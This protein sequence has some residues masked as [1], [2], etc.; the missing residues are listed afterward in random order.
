LTNRYYDLRPVV[1][2]T[3]TGLD[4][5][6]AMKRSA[7]R[8]SDTYM[9]I[10][11][12]YLVVAPDAGDLKPLLERGWTLLGEK[13]GLPP[14]VAWTDDYINILASAAAKFGAK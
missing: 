13:D 7:L 5:T 2:A 6:G 10:A 1:K 14:G 9:P 8:S 3:L 4:L 12:L 11:T